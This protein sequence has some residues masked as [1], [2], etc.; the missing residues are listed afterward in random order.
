MRV[1]DAYP[2]NIVRCALKF[3]ALTFA[4]PGEVRR[5]EWAEISGDEWRIPSEK[6]KMER[7]HIVPLSR[8]ALE[9]LD[10]MR[11]L[12]GHGKYVFPSNRTPDGS[13]P[14]SDATVLAALR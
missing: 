4:R 13:R 2:H 5:A 12:T 14:M 3:S 9:I 10:K 7:P 11:Q 8:Q 1:I 6:M